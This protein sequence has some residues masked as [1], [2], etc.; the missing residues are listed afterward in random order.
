VQA[1][2][3]CCPMERAP[4]DLDAMPLPIRACP[5][6]GTAAMRPMSLDEGG[7]PGASDISDRLACAKC[8][9]RGLA[10]EFD[11]P[12]EYADFLEDLEELS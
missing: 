2:S 11:D 1:C 9:Y 4:S 5:Q 7:V 12:R 3:A 8:G 10:L 6:C